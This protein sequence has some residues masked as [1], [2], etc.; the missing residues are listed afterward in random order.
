MA[1]AFAQRADPNQIWPRTISVSGV[2][3]PTLRQRLDSLN[4]PAIEIGVKT[5]DRLNPGAHHGNVYGNR[6]EK[7]PRFCRSPR[8]HVYFSTQTSTI[9]KRPHDLEL[10][11]HGNEGEDFL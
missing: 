1:S 8:Q 3:P 9:S 6:A 11:G 5:Q 7:I 4:P 2:T 10:R